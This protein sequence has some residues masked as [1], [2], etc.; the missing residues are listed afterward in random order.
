[1]K[2]FARRHAL[3]LSLLLG[4]AFLTLRS[5]L[6]ATGGVP[7]VPLD[8]AFIHFEYAR[9]FWEGRG[10]AYTQGAA[11]VPGA[12]S[13]LWPLLFTLP[14]G[15][16]LR[17]E[18]VIWAAWLFG[19]AALGMLGYETRRASQ[20]L[21]SDDGALAAE[22]MVLT[23]GGYVWFA[24]SG[25]E[26]VPLAWILMRTARR[27]AEWLEQPSAERAK[28]WELVAYA[29][30]APLVRPEGV[31]ATIAVAATLGY[32]LR[33]RRRALGAL[34]LSFARLPALFMLL[35]TGSAT[36]TTAMVKWLPLSPY[37]ASFGKLWHAVLGNV[38]LLFGTLL[39]GEVWS[40]VFLPQGS[41]VVLWPALPA[42][43]WLGFRRGVKAR[44]L[45]IAW[46]GLGMLLP[47]TYDSFLWNRL[48]YLWPFMAAWFVGVAAVSDVVGL[49]VARYAP[50]FERVR[51]LASG[52]VVGGLLSHLGW[53]LDDLA[54]SANAIRAQQ[55]E[56]GHWAKA[57]LPR[58]AVVGV[59]DTGAIGYFSE[60]RVF[61]VV[62]L[63]T[64]GEARYWVAGTGSRFEHY[65]RL[66]ASALPTHF[67]V[68]PEWF[69]LPGL[70][71]EYRTARHVPGATILGGETMVAYDADYARLGSGARP[72]AP[73]RDDALLAD[74]LDVADLESESEH[75]YELFDAVALEDVALEQDGVMDGARR[76]RERERFEL[77]LPAAGTLVLRVEGEG[78]GELSL[79]TPSET[80][81]SLPLEAGTWREFALALPARGDGA[82]AEIRVESRGARFSSL[83]YWSYRPAPATGGGSLGQ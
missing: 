7:A 2:A 69:A 77:R 33:G 68:Y 8:D 20:R 17:A 22:L 38:A 12:T 46:V 83:H 6:R 54:T 1:M 82:R 59:N 40:A 47:A 78:T 70:L 61:D 66:G 29:A 25:M 39:N 58:D 50:G 75:R 21:V 55:G 31:L 44:A 34:V 62:G 14:Y 65:E 11:P 37:Y 79:K 4:L 41:A 80:L 53:T 35:F 43:V 13:L 32:G 9:S 72:L 60:R 51:L 49:V 67:I 24:S 5:V 63:T 71:G 19:W 42:L 64:R 26:V 23:F 74:E 30:L 27:A 81:G 56:L 16:G 28:P 48:R 76:N 10:F 57:E 15:L 3:R 18:R 36:P 45:L 73:P 52:A